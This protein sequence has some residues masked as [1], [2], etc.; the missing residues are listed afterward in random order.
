[1]YRSYVEDPLN[2]GDVLPLSKEELHHMKKVL[3]V[4]NGEKVEL[5]NGKG[6][7]A[8]GEFQEEMRI[9]SSSFSPPPPYKK[10]L[11]LANPL[12]PH[13]ELIIE[14]ATELGITDF[15]LFPSTR[16]PIQDYSPSKKDRLHKITIAALKQCKR[17]HLPTITYLTPKNLPHAY[18]LLGDPKGKQLPITIPQKDVGFIIGPESG[19]TPEEIAYLEQKASPIKLSENILRCE[20]AAIVASFILTSG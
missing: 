18:Y 4:K 13:L 19:F 9:I 7:L 12:Q 11:A 3:R 8:I 6:I 15:C 17:L 20:T 14:K 2:E 1:M 16:S 5:V 10:I